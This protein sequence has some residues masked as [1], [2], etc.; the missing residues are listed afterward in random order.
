VLYKGG[1]YAPAALC[2]N[3]AI[4]LLLKATLIYYDRSFKPQAANH[5][6]AG[7][8]RTLRNKVNPKPRTSIPEYFY[9]E[10]RYQS[11]SR[12]PHHDQGLLIPAS[13]LV[14]L[15]RSFRELLVLVPFQHNT[16]L[17]RNLASPDRKKRAQLT[18]ANAEIRVLRRFLGTSRGAR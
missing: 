6:I 15:D 4:E 7:M 17:R 8:L 18:R 11:L 5:R 1:I 16:E 12:Y 10:K 3:V 9:A 2:A 13:F 14:D